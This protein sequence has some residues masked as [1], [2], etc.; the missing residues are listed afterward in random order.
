[1]I[2]NVAGVSELLQKILVKAGI[3]ASERD[4]KEYDNFWIVKKKT[5]ACCEDDMESEIT[6]KLNFSCKEK[7]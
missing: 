5:K 7:Q 1:M 4:I 2:I 3:C 6:Q